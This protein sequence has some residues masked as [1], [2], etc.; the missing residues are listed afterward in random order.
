MKFHE[1]ATAR[2]KERFVE[3]A[4]ERADA[5]FSLWFK[6]NFVAKAADHTLLAKSWA[7]IMKAELGKL[8]G[9]GQRP[10]LTPRLR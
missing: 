3:I 10:I 2:Q 1:W 6:N 8:E 7:G 4:R 9:T 5:K